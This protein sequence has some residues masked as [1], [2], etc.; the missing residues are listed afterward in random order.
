MR[1]R[2]MLQK[3]HKEGDCDVAKNNLDSKAQ[4]QI[5]GMKN[6]YAA[7]ITQLDW[8]CNEAKKIFRACFHE[9]EITQH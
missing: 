3:Q 6:N 4:E 8:Y 5:V 1:W 7:T 2:Q 9:G